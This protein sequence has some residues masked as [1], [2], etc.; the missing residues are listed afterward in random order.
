V[1]AV[2]R[3]RGDRPDIPGIA[4]V[5]VCGAVPAV[6]GQVAVAPARGELAGVRTADSGG[7][8]SVTN[9]WTDS[10]ETAPESGGI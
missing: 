10:Q 4:S 8:S 6:A 7:Q 3:A 9:R 1:R 5:W 2:I